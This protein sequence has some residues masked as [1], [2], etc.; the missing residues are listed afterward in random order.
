MFNLA[1]IPVPNLSGR[2]VLV[3]GA[4]RGIGAALVRVLVAQGARVFA[5]V[6]G[7]PEA[8][9]GDATVFQLDVTRQA[10]VD[11]AIARVRADAGRL[12]VLVNNAGIISPIG[13]LASLA[14][15]SLAPAFA[16]NVIGVHRTVVAALPLLRASQ[17]TIVNAG[18]G[19]AT[20]PMEGWT[21]YCTSKAGVHMLTRL[22]ALE[23]GPEGIQ[24]FFIGIPPTDTAMQAEIR[25]AGLNP[26]SKIP[27]D[28]LV[29][30]AVP[31]SVMAYLCSAGARGID[32]VL[33]DV[34]QDR[35]KAMM[36]L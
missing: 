4:T 17:G 26:I 14:S 25:A 13:P 34:R 1:P 2:S 35:F 19:A 10:D 27:R 15:D 16:V 28:H 3:T 11:A 7:D 23:L 30:T 20:T 9:P 8:L 18:T 32:E 21:A 33:L 5:G 31:A 36:P 24:S 6:L 22:M 29:P 12:D